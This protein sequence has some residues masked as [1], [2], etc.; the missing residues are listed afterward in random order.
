VSVR[1]HLGDCEAGLHELADASVDSL[2]TDPPAGIG[3][4]GKEWDKPGTLGVSGGLAMPATTSSRNPSC[5]ACG[6]RKRAG[7]KTKGCD[8]PTPDWND[9]DYRLKDRDAFIAFLQPIMTKCLRVLKPGAHGLVWALPRTSHWTATAL[10]QAG[11]EIRDVITHHFGTG[12]PKSLNVSKAIDDAAGATREVVG[13][14]DRY[15]DGI[16]RR[17][18][19]DKNEVFGDGLTAN[20]VATI[21]AP[22]TEAAKQWDGWGTA[23]KPASEHWI[24]VRKPLAGTVAANVQEHGTGAIN[25]DA[26]RIPGPPSSGGAARNTALGLIND[27]GWK[28]TPGSIDRTM[29]EGR[30]PANLVLSHTEWCEPCTCL[31]GCPVAL[32]DAQTA[33]LKSGGSIGANTKGAGPRRNEI[34]GID[35]RDRG[36]WNGYGD[37]GGASRFFYVAKPTKEEREL[38]LNLLAR[39]GRRANTHPTVKSVSLMSWLVK[40]VTPPGGLVLDPFA[41]S[42]ST[43]VAALREK[44]GFIGWEKDSEYHRVAVARIA[45]AKDGPLFAATSLDHAPAEHRERARKR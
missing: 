19:G 25:I 41:G 2:V 27:D 30:W 34:L 15:L 44:F 5:R 10:E 16:K 20:G 33:T 4:M 22:A 14:R 42:G 7:P 40:L 28:P 36:E 23:L 45:S 12:F 3:F 31:P 21:T 1:V 43:G 29:S 38:D 11:F 24:L 9:L 17:N 13:E 37:T 18:D 6:G 26:C 39:T 32:L 8:C 35:T